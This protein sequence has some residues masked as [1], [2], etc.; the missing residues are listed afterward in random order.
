MK[1]TDML[2]KVKELIGVELSEEVKLAQATLENGTV[3]ESEDF[4]AGS[5]VF[6]VTEDEKV[7]LPIGDYTLEDGEILVVEEEGIIASIGAAEEAPAE[8]EVEAQEEEMGYAT[9]E[10]LAEVKAMIEEIKSMLE[11]K[12]EMSEESPNTIK[13]EETTTKTVYASEEEVE[14]SAEPIAKITHNPEAETKRNLNLFS[15]KRPMTTADK[16]NAKN[17]EH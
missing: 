2:N 17:C 9:K 10:E 16:S 11:S 12:E 13:S 1:A 15:Q 4:A 3:I 14:L 5:E 7:A 6:I 8:E